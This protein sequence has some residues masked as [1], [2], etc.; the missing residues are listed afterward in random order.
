MGHDIVYGS[1]LLAL[2][3]AVQNNIKI[4]LESPSF[5]PVYESSENKEDWA[6]LYLQLMIDGNVVGGDSVTAVRI[7]DDF[8]FAVGKGN[9]LNKLKY[10]NIYIFSDKNIMGLPGPSKKNKSFKVIDSLEPISLG[11]PHKSYIKTQDRFVNEI[12]VYKKGKKAKTEIHI[13]SQL[14][15]KQLYQFDYSDTMARFKCESI[16]KEHGFE[17]S[18]NGDYTRPLRLDTVAR[19]IIEPMHQYKDTEKIKFIYGN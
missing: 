3:R 6:N 4:I 11:K 17:G 12:H 16:L 7:D 18:P 10:K 13:I 1:S 8:V 19:E 2:Q 15:E 9:V 14:S 5:P